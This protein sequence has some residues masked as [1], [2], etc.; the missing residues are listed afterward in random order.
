MYGW[1]FQRFCHPILPSYVLYFHQ[2]VKYNSLSLLLTAHHLCH[3]PAATAAK[4]T[5]TTG[6]L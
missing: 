6:V 5:Q 4:K 1:Y 3:Q 2:R